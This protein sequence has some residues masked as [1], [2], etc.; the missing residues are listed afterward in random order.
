MNCV[1]V[2]YI[3]ILLPEMLYKSN[4]EIFLCRHS[5]DVKKAVLHFNEVFDYNEIIIII[6]LREREWLSSGYSFNQC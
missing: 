5:I 6:I 2:K 4:I 1:L 3:L